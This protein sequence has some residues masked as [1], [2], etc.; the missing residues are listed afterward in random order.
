M[1]SKPVQ[2]RV[3]QKDDYSLLLIEGRFLTGTDPELL[4]AKAEEIKAL[5]CNKL[6]VDCSQMPQIGSTAIGFLVALYTTVT[7]GMGGRFVLAG[8]QPRVRE[9]LELTRLSE[10]IPIASDPKA[11]V[12]WLRSS[13]TAGTTG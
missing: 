2:L 10:V 7:R 11:G 12:A 1:I 6:L 4:R 3:E 13:A 5:D 9:V 8:L